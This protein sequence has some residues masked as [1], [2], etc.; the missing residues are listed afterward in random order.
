MPVC[1]KTIPE[2]PTEECEYLDL[3]SNN[4]KTLLQQ[5]YSEEYM[6]IPSTLPQTTENTENSPL[7]MNLRL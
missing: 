7:Y 2:K 1:N 3:D 5:Q 6:N 4:K